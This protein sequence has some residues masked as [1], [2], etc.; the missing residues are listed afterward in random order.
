[1][2]PTKVLNLVLSVYI[3]LSALSPREKIDLAQ[4][5]RE[6]TRIQTVPEVDW[7]G[8]VEATVEEQ[9]TEQLCREMQ[10]LG[11]SVQVRVDAGYR[12]GA[13]SELEVYLT[14]P[15]QESEAARQT[16]ERLLG[17]GTVIWEGEE[18]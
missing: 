6:L 2:G 4:I 9:L 14:G 16:A 13:L 5:R 8:M 3:I 15:A 1:G 18:E 11:L 7:R 17:G 12:E 10:L